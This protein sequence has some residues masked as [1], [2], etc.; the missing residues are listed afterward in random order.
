MGISIGNRTGTSYRQS[1]SKS[2]YEI[3][4]GNRIETH[5]RNSYRKSNLENPPPVDVSRI[6]L[7]PWLGCLDKSDSD[8]SRLYI[9]MCGGREVL[10]RFTRLMEALVAATRAGISILE[11]GQGRERLKRL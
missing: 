1:Y 9:V 4:I 7:F 5:Y 10:R 6:S 2:L 11:G 8:I 3:T